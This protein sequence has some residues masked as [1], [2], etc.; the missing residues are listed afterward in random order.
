[1]EKPNLQ[2]NNVHLLY[3]KLGETPL[4]CLERFK[5]VKS[6]LDAVNIRP[7]VEGG[8][9][10]RSN[11]NVPVTYAGRLDPMAEGLL[12]A[13]SGD[14]VHEKEKYL[15]LP[16]T[17]L[18][19]VLW[20]FETD[21]L[22]MLGVVSNLNNSFSS[23]LF[24]STHKFLL[25]FCSV[26]RR[27]ACE[28][29]QKDTTT[30]NYSNPALST[31]EEVLR[32]SMGKFEQKYPVYSSRP[33]NGKPLFQWAREGKLGEVE[34]PSHEVELLSADFVSRKTVSDE[35][36]LA[37]ILAKIDLV[38]GDFRQG[39]IKEKWRE[40]LASHLQKEFVI[41][42]LRLECSSG[43]YVRQFVADLA[44]KFGLTAI[45]FHILRERVGDFGIVDTV[46]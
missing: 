20:G 27:R 15:G 16:K 5:K 21:T 37:D 35:K 46:K 29:S 33:V 9:T 26:S 39:E 3:K 28:V 17:Y 19:E 10:E 23:Y 8:S 36:L 18:M 38:S 24:E 13:L 31:F 25:K 41:D 34:V 30:T 45:T 2:N 11:A 44:Q 4:E 40:V 43:F 22:D 7:T 1:M 6:D 12:L 42:T 14:A 32:G